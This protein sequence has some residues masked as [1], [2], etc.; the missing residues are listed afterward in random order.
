M[1]SV[2]AIKGW[3]LNILEARM[4]KVGNRRLTDADRQAVAFDFLEGRPRMRDQI[5]VDDPP[6]FASR[7]L[8]LK[9]SDPSNHG[10]VRKLMRGQG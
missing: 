9:S 1:R 4:R 10:K 7:W 6:T 5:N 2:R 3:P 8:F